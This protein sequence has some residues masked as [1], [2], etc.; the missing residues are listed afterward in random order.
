MT[1]GP[2]FWNDLGTVSLA[3]FACACFVASLVRG[4]VVIGR[5]HR[6]TVARLDARAEKDA[7]TIEILSRAVT[8]RQSDE[9]ATTRILAALRDAMVKD[10]G[11]E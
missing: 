4:W 6:D 10:K 9:Q 3:V 5:Y 11:P 2:A 7:T 1:W 8:E